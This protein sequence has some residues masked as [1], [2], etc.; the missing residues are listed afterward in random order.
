[1]GGVFPERDRSHSPA[2][3]T[4]SKTWSQSPRRRS[5]TPPSRHNPADRDDEELKIFVGG[6]AVTWTSERVMQGGQREVL[7]VGCARDLG[8]PNSDATIIKNHN[9]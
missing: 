5:R 9:D 2:T 4:P 1:M 7:V 3:P 8:G 6:T